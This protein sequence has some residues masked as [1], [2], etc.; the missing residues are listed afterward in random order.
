VLEYTARKNCPNWQVNVRKVG[1]PVLPEGVKVSRSDIGAPFIYNV[2]KFRFWLR[3]VVEAAEGELLCL[4]DADT[5]VLRPLDPIAAMDFDVAITS[6]RGLTRLPLNGGVVFVRANERSRRFMRAWWDW[7]VKLIGDWR[8]HSIWRQKYAGMN[9]AALGAL[10]ESGGTQMAKVLEIP[11]AEWNCESSS[12][13]RVDLRQARVV[14]VKGQ[15]RR[16]IM[17][18]DKHKLS[19]PQRLTIAQ[20]WLRLEKE[21]LAHG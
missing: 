4:I 17:A 5:M 2:Y 9:Q 15:M 21:A 3:S 16:G 14:H 20:E 13:D 7:N 8:L 11:C 18:P 12:W 19:T 1:P 10:L 6:K